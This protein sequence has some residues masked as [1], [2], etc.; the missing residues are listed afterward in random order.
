MCN[1]Y[2]C[3]DLILPQELGLTAVRPISSIIVSSW[4]QP[5]ISIE[6]LVNTISIEWVERKRHRE[7]DSNPIRKVRFRNRDCNRI[8][9][10]DIRSSFGQMTHGSLQVTGWRF[11]ISRGHHLLFPDR[12]MG[13]ADS[14]LRIIRQK[15][16]GNQGK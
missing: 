13:N 12:C 1:T 16:K 8:A 11:P 15:L 14:M 10:Y 2:R 6:A 7:T 5:A 9:G 4:V 3:D